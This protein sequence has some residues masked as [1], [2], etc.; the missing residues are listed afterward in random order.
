MLR[1]TNL[2][3][4]SALTDILEGHLYNT[5]LADILNIWI[6][7]MG[8]D[9]CDVI[10]NE[11][12][13]EELTELVLTKPMIIA[14]FCDSPGNYIEVISDQGLTMLGSSPQTPIIVVRQI[15][16]SLLSFEEGNAENVRTC[17][18]FSTANL[19]PTLE[20]QRNVMYDLPQQFKSQTQIGSLSP[21]NSDQQIR[22]LYDQQNKPNVRFSDQQPNQQD[23]YHSLNTH[24][25]LC[26]LPS[27]G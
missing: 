5:A 24:R 19:A 23:P 1:K 8:Q 3:I 14:K 18:E 2:N 20:S 11:L 26:E 10:L 22:N 27:A 13:Y 9:A 15:I 17:H 6:E 21:K 12:R 16:E 25:E 7:Y 4:E